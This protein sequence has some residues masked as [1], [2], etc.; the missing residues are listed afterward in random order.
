MVIWVVIPAAGIG[1][2]MQSERPKQ[3]L[4]LIDKCVLE[5]SVAPFINMQEVKR[6]IV[7]VKPGDATWST[8]S[9]SHHA[10]VEGIAGGKERYHSVLHGLQHIQAQAQLDD[11]V[12]VHD[13]VRPCLT[14]EE[15]YDLLRA[16]E[17]HR[18]G[19]VLGVP[20]RDTTKVVN[21]AGSIVRTTDRSIL[22]NALTPQ[23]FRYGLLLNAINKAIQEK[24]TPTDEAQ[25][26][27][28]ADRIPIMIKGRYTNIKIT[29][30]DDLHYARFLL[31]HRK[32]KK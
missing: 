6:I 15:I 28:L 13:G 7:A 8:L 27:E 32:Q 20:V 2:R 22:W 26:I 16:V 9:L 29:E 23:I 31:N 12:I 30:P 10:K 17:G 24:K 11:W 21:H 3:Y 1:S 5:E 14:Q 19:G 25:A 4:P 18:V